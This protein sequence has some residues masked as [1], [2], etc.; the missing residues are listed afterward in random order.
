LFL[1]LCL[2]VAI[3]ASAV[4]VVDYQNVG[5]PAFCGA[6]SGCMAV[7]LAP[8]TR[9]LTEIFHMPLPSFGLTAFVI[10][11]GVALY[12]HKR[13]ARLVL[14]GLCVVGGLVGAVLLS[15]QAHSIGAFCPW[16][17]TV[18]VSAILAAF[19]A[20]LSLV[21]AP[22]LPDGAT[23]A[24]FS[25]KGRVAWSVLGAAA[26]VVPFVWGAYP[27]VPPAP[28]DVAK[29][30]VPG[31]LTLVEFTDFECPYCR[32]LHPVIEEVRAAHPDRIALV[33]RMKPLS[34]HPGARPAALAYLCAPEAKRDAVAQGLYEV[35]ESELTPRGVVKVAEG[36]GLDGAAV[37][38][39]M[40]SP[41]AE[42]ALASDEA[43]FER[44]GAAGLPRTYVGDRL[45]MGF[46]PDRLRSVVARE[47]EGQHAA[48][49]V[50]AMFA[51]L[52]AGY[53]AGCWGTLRRARRFEAAQPKPAA[54]GP[55]QPG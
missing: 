17:V 3:V 49:P 31:K 2:L 24:L 55:A 25:P 14:A 23:E 16:C 45:V 1:R 19:A 22:R 44:L 9:T 39:C 27:V 5:D 10:L 11:F 38:K 48:L 41:E 29:Q 21:W 13:I 50:W 18:D 6:G 12:A 36:A 42:K 43:M 40:E 51:L 52:A 32:M 53:A 37:A 30:Q 35:D 33:R 47:L 7:R 54:D 20:V 8:V 15:I 28:A 4:L 34:F 26:V 46:N